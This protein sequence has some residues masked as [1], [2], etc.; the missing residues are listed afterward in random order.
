MVTK[1]ELSA[2]RWAV[3]EAAS[4]RGGLAP[5]DHAAFDA[6]VAAAK[7]ALRKLSIK[8]KGEPK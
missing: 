2:L 3:R 5:V 7:A 4:W 6:R 1:A 8:P